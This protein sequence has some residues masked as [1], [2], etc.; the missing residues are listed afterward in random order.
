MTF[1]GCF[2]IE[3]LNDPE[4]NNDFCTFVQ[5]EGYAILRLPDTHII[6][7]IQHSIHEWFK[8]N[9]ALTKREQFGNLI[10]KSP[11]GRKFGWTI[12]PSN[13]REKMEVWEIWEIVLEIDSGRRMRL[14]WRFCCNLVADDL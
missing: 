13:N 14:Y 5:N 6:S 3:D 12:E 8:N 7:N 4:H 10:E 11:E 9:D 2:A 1:T